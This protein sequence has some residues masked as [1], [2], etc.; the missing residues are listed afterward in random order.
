[1]HRDQTAIDIP[2]L[3]PAPLQ[4]EFTKTL[5]GPDSPDDDNTGFGLAAA[6][7]DA[8]EVP[9]TP[10]KSDALASWEELDAHA[11]S[12]AEPVDAWA[13]YDERED[14]WVPL[15]GDSSGSV[16]GLKD[17]SG[18]AF[19][20]AVT[21]HGAGAQGRA[22]APTV[23]A[24]LVSLASDD[25]GREVI[26]ADRESSIGRDPNST[27]VLGHTSA[28]RQHAQIFRDEDR[29]LVVDQ[30][31]ANGTFV[32]GE[33]I[34]RARLQSGDEVAFGSSAFRF[35]ETG[36]VFKPG[37][38]AG[39]PPV[40][41]AAAVAP[42]MAAAA[43]SQPTATPSWRLALLV[44][45]LMIVGVSV[46][47]LYV[48]LR[49]G[50]GS[51]AARRTLIFEHYVR[52][53]DSFK[54]HQWDDAENEFNAILALD[55]GHVRG[56]EYMAAIAEEKA[57]HAKVEQA[58]DARRTGDLLHAYQLASSATNTEFR[59]EAHQVLREVDAELDARMGRAQAALEA[60]R[61]AEA[62]RILGDVQRVHPGRQD[63]AT[64]LQRANQIGNPVADAP[65]AAA[66]TA[67][68]AAEATGTA[69][70]TARR[71][72]P[73]RPNRPDAGAPQ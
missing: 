63:V 36:D 57:A 41:G 32:N 17:S 42:V 40:A 68:A 11:E 16:S 47:S 18:A 33:R 66:P 64:L 56:R 61:T 37:D 15:T 46:A 10:S 19:D 12:V 3:P 7:G 4:H 23:A 60:G 29:Y 27:I 65:A 44:G 58:R 1:M 38:T 73:E 59:N 67:S 48:R 54:G 45:I 2:A 31:S 70:Q 62:L 39:V 35:L 34:D 69:G 13:S 20:R 43:A 21:D 53:T 5:A 30:R 24:R 8:P 71:N 25:M 14:G 22:V 72:G 6:Y 49:G 28:S 9:E 55:P 51:T 50:I 26:L 52:G